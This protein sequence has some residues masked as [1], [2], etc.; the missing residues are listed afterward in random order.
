MPSTLTFIH[1]HPSTLTFSTAHVQAACPQGWTLFNNR[2]FK[3]VTK[4]DT[5]HRAQGVCEVENSHLAS[6]H[7]AAELDFLKNVV[8]ASGVYQQGAWLGGSDDG[9]EG[10]WYWID[11]SPFDFADWAQGQPD[12]FGV[13]DCLMM[14]PYDKLRWKDLRCGFTMPFICSKRSRRPQMTDFISCSP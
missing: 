10:T 2:C 12:N 1:F 14:T 3:L 7:S 5:F 9:S 13:E 11:G 4:P 6:V 8:R